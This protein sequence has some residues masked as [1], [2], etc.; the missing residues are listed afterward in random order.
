MKTSNLL[1]ILIV[2][3]FFLSSCNKD[4]SDTKNGESTEWAP[5]TLP[6]GS[7]IGWEGYYTYPDESKH[8]SESV[9][10]TQTFIEILNK[11]DCKSSWSTD[12]GTYTYNKTSPSTATLSFSIAQNVLGHVRT[13]QYKVQLEFTKQ[14]EFTMS[15]TKFIYSTMNG[16]STVNLHCTGE[17]Y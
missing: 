8:Y 13:F 6:I 5:T 4:E 15:G 12:W 10:I 1:F 7:K 16:S 9:G 11:T 14:N 3:C 17:I 2:N